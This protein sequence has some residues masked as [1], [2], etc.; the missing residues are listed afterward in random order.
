MNVAMDYIVARFRALEAIN[1]EFQSVI[2]QL[3]AI[4]LER[5]TDVLSPIF[6]QANQI[7]DQLEAIKDTW[8]NDNTIEQVTETVAST[9]TTNVTAEFEDYRHRYWGDYASAPTEGPEGQALEIGVMYF[10]TTLDAMRVYGASGWKNAGSA[11]AGIMD[12]IAPIVATAGQTIF[13]IPGGYDVGYLIIAV[14]GLV[15][16]SSDYTATNGSTVVFSTGL[17]VGDEVSGIKFGAV[18]LT[19]VY[20]K[21]QADALYRTI[22]D[23]YTK[24]QVDSAVG[25][26]ASSKADSSSVYSKT[27]SDARYA[28]LSLSNLTDAAAALANL[29][30]V[31]PSGIATFTNKRITARAPS[32]A[33]PSSP[34]AIASDDLDA[35][36]V[37]ALA[38]ALTLNAP[39]GTP[40]HMQP[41]KL[42]FKDNGTS[43]VIT[44]VGGASK[45]FRDT[46]GLLT[47]SG[48][49]FTY[50]TVA[51]KIVYFGIFFNA[52]D[53]RWDIVGIAQQA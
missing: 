48:S 51:G 33:S 18:T 3:K 40:T 27:A 13:T 8:E 10:D 43:R 45:T 26:L 31:S 15:I 7:A 25:A 16:P 41:L 29:N 12:E 37:T 19:S 20:T 49:N 4:G 53:D 52:A 34:L 32:V 24:A 38:S 17:T 9:V 23:S 46:T 39:S 42:S 2:E 5:V 44:F 11:V 47:V 50:A 22:A 36:S 6:E 14:N 28:N 30:G 35:Y 1:P 21:A